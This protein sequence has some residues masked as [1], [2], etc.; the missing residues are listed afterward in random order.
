MK[1][2]RTPIAVKKRVCRNGNYNGRFGCGSD[3]P[4]YACSVF[5]FRAVPKMDFF[6]DSSSGFGR[7]A[8][9]VGFFGIYFLISGLED[10][11]RVFMYHGAEHK[12]INC[13]EH[14]LELNVENVRNS[15]R[16]HKRCGTSFLFLVVCISIIFF[17]FIH[18]QSGLLRIVIRL[19][20]VPV[21][22]GCAYEVIR[23]A[24]RS[25]HAWINLI[26]KP[27]LA[28]QKLT[29]REPDDSIIEV[30]IASVEAVFDWKAYIKEMEELP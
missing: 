25:E 3:C 13:I 4:V 6:P 27:G 11:Q 29:T 1:K 9:D 28:L 18:T 23:L 19:L 5:H 16:L 20:L 15:S 14:G 17:L 22:A 24:G 2:R 30:G 8:A 7:R 10:I 26:S 12:C 21:I